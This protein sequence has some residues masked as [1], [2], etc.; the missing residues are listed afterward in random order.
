MVNPL[1]ML[2]ERLAD[3]TQADLADRIGISPQFLSE[4]LHEKRN[5]S[6]TVLNFLGLEKVITYRPKT[7]GKA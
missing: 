7:R 5:P 1:K 6:D 2:R 3:C 4:I